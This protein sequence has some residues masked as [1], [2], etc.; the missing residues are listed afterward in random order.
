MHWTQAFNQDIADRAEQALRKVWHS[1]TPPVLW[2]ARPVEER[3]SPPLTWL[4]ALGCVL[5]EAST[6]AWTSSLSSDEVGTA[7]ILR[8]AVELNMLAARTLPI[9]R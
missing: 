3:N 2:S 8:A 6:P 9:S 7:A 1:D 5:A 4:R